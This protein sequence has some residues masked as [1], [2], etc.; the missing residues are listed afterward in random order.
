MSWPHV[1]TN[2]N[3]KKVTG[4]FVIIQN[5]LVYK[6]FSFGY[7]CLREHSVQS[8]LP[9]S[10]MNLHHP[11][12]PIYK[13]HT[14]SKNWHWAEV[15]KIAQS[16]KAFAEDSIECKQGK[17]SERIVRLSQTPFLKHQFLNLFI[18]IGDIELWPSK[19]RMFLKLESAVSWTLKFL[20]P[21]GPARMEC[22]RFQV[23]QWINW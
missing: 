12:P 18:R 10:L 21:L 6:L 11:H 1:N 15:V 13:E 19:V 16:L 4:V 23:S 20:F 8:M 9:T 2:I 7:T 5:F 17:S 3:W 22:P 14:K